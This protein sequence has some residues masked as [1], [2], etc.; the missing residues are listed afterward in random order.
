MS[1]ES[2]VIRSIVKPEIKLDDVILEDV[3]TGTSDELGD[4][5]GVQGRQ[6]QKDT[7][8]SYPLITVNG[9]VFKTKEILEFLLDATGFIPTVRFKV[10]LADTA[11]FKSHSMPKDGDIVSIFIRAKNDAFKPIRNDYVITNVNDSGGGIE[12]R[13]STILIEG[14]L[15]IKNLRDEIIES[16]NGTSFD[17]LKQVSQKLKMGFATNE[18]ST[19]DTQNWICAGDNLFNFIRHVTDHA[20]KDEKCFYDC[21]IDVYYHLNF[22]NVNA[23]VEGEEK[24]NAAI[25]DITGMKD[26][27]SDDNFEEGTQQQ[28]KKLLTD[29]ASVSGTN[30]YIKS[31]RVVNNSSE[32]SRRYGYRSFAQFFDQKSGKTWD[33]FVDPIVSEGSADKKILLKGR[34]YPKKADGTAEDDSWITQNKKYWLGVQYRDVH[35]KYLYSELWNTRN[36][37]ELNKMYIEANVERWNPN[38]YRGE[39]LPIILITQDDTLKR[40]SDATPNESTIPTNETPAVADQFYSG[41]YMVSG[42]KIMYNMSPE[43]TNYEDPPKELPPNLYQIF[44]LARREWPVPSTG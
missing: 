1:Q 20:W 5:K 25:L 11:V 3:F 19:T 32:I 29:M 27:N 26:F 4:Q 42:M 30:M 24:L 22:I 43:S 38:V 15:Y 9:Y 10:L 14:E 34:A 8:T 18:T 21:F 23:Q 7:G 28:T 44:R 6:Y 17:V 40:V 16:F 35:D 39:K 12:G 37:E 36:R 13:G 31:Y 2:S 41:F 33:I